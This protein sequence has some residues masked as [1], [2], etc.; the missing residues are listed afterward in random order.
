MSENDEPFDNTP[1]EEEIPTTAIGEPL[2]APLAT[3]DQGQEMESMW[4]MERMVTPT[5]GQLSQTLKQFW[6]EFMARFR[7]FAIPLDDSRALLVVCHISTDHLTRARPQGSFPTI[8]GRKS[9]LGVDD[10]PT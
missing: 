7:K 9:L 1:R 8:L 5:K 6:E 3:A 2:P 10:A 4:Q